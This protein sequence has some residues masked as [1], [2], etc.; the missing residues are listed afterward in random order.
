MIYSS[1]YPWIFSVM[2]KAKNFGLA[3]HFSIFFIKSRGNSSFHISSNS[4][5]LSASTP[6]STSFIIRQGFKGISS[7]IICVETT[8]SCFFGS[9]F[10]FFDPPVNYAKMSPSSLSSS[11]S[12]IISDCYLTST[13]LFWV[14]YYFLITSSFLYFAGSTSL[15]SAT[16]VLDLDFPECSCNS[17]PL[18][19]LSAGKKC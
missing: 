14:S 4:F 1:F 7:I 17:C 10:F 9:F 15:N 8:F 11:D 5:L 6:N 3:M 18:P 2:A 13:I 12:Y 19:S 16:I